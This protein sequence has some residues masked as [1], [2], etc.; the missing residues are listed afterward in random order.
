[1]QPLDGSTML[2]SSYSLRQ[3]E[4]LRSEGFSLFAGALFSSKAMNF[5]SLWFPY[6]GILNDVQEIERSLP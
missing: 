2:S 4:L 3:E 6:G 5:L 1:M